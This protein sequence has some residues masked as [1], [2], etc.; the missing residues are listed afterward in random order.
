MF[1]FVKDMSPP[2]AC[3]N[4]KRIHRH[5]I[6]YSIYQYVS[7][8]FL[9]G[10]LNF[11]LSVQLGCLRI[12]DIFIKTLPI[13]FQHVKHISIVPLQTLRKSHGTVP[14]Q[15]VTHLGH[16]R[17]CPLICSKFVFRRLLPRL[18][19]ILKVSDVCTGYS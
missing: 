10:I 2:F 12:S 1:F 19:R 8:K 18:I 15:V 4:L 9:V 11:L 14:S 13:Y 17:F 3:D 6:H 5:L 7:V 16:G